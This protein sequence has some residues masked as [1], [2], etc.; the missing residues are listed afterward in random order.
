MREK[1]R[2]R[3]GQRRGGRGQ[4]KGKGKTDVVH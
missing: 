1:E 3:A 2:E 4:E